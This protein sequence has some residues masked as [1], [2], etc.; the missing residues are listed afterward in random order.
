MSQI[1]ENLLPGV[2]SVESPFFTQIFEAEGVDPEI[3][4]IARDLHHNGFAI[5]DFMR[6]TTSGTAFGFRMRGSST[7]T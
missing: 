2:P 3:R 6:V 5:I 4:R 1:F 7:T